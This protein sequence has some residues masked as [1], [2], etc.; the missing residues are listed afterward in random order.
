MEGA[1]AIHCNVGVVQTSLVGVIPVF[2]QETMSY[3]PQGIPNVI[4]LSLASKYFHITYDSQDGN[5]FRLHKSDGS[6]NEFR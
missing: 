4:S 5:F 1:M 6:Y 2:Y 3:H